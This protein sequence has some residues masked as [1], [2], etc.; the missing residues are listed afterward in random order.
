MARVRLVV[1]LV[2]SALGSAAACSSGESSKPL[3]MGDTVFVDVEASTLPP[4]PSSDADLDPDG[5]FAP[6]DG[7]Q[8]YGTVYDSYA[9]LTVCAPPDGGASS[10][11]GSAAS[12]ADG[13]AATGCLPFPASCTNTSAPDCVCLFGV[14]S[15]QIP[16]IDPSCGVTKSG[17]SIYCP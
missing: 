14:Y 17:F 7:S 12:E 11:D 9:A 8:A 16:C 10:G 15:A 3:G 5:V 4:Q 6:V 2:T 1:L 13:A